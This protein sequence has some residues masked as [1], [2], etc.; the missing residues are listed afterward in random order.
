MQ[1]VFGCKTPETDEEL[2]K[3]LRL[4]GEAL[5]SA[6]VRGVDL[7]PIQPHW[8]PPNVEFIVDDIEDEWVHDTDYDFAHLRFVVTVLRDTT[9]VLR[10]VF[11]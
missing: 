2:T 9:G 1:Y 6:R 11:E 8:V 7:S 3:S 5:P 10:K 4:V